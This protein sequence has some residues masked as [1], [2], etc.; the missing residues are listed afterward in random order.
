MEE[1]RK[2][3]QEEIEDTAS[4]NPSP[5]FLEWATREILKRF[6]SQ[7]VSDWRKGE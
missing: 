3:I 5:D 1:L 6:V 4:I 7:I 2:M